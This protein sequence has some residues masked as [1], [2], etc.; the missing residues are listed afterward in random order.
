MVNIIRADE[1]HMDGIL[2]IER[3]SF[4]VPWSERSFME[5]IRAPEAVFLVA[6]EDGSVGGF[7]I[8]RQFLDEGEIFNIAVSEKHRRCGMGEALLSAALREG[9]LKGLRRVF[10]E[11]RQSNLPA[12]SLYEKLGFEKIGL[13]KNYYEK[14]TEDA[15]LM[16]AELGRG[17]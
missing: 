17:L 6:E 2:E 4:S 10:L 7:C 5:E 12:V 9:A 15:I 11:V 16:A 1:K 14:P 8:L 3:A 13:R